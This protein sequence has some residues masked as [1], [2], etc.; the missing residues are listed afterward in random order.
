MSKEIFSEFHFSSII[1]YGHGQPTSALGNADVERTSLTVPFNDAP[2]TDDL[3]AFCLRVAQALGFSYIDG[4]VLTSSGK[5]HTSQFLNSNLED[6]FA[7]FLELLEDVSDDFEY[8]DQFC[9]EGVKKD[10]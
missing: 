2:T 4:V 10:D 9:T 8:H 1:D 6:E 7:D 5:F 3:A